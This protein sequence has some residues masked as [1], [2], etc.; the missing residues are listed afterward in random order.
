LSIGVAAVAVV[1]AIGLLVADAIPDALGRESHALV[2]AL[3]LALVALAYILHQPS[4]RPSLGQ[5]VKAGLLCAAFL[6]WAAAQVRPSLP[7]AVND[8]AIALFVT[9]LALIVGEDL[10]RRA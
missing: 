6:L 9:D 4:R 8:A 2:S 1:L 7:V 10:R 3:P 5:A